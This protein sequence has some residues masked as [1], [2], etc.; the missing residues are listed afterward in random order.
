MITAINITK[1]LMWRSNREMRLQRAGEAESPAE[2]SMA[3]GPL[4]ARGK[5][6]FRHPSIR[7]VKSA[8][9]AG[10]VLA[11]LLSEWACIRRPI[12]VVPQIF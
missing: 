5:G 1:P 3:N 10:N 9:S 8:L 4:R 7:D 2:S 12:K 11:F 6:R